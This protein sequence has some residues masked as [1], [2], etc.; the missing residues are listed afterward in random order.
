MIRGLLRQ[1]C[2]FFAL[3]AATYCSDPLAADSQSTLTTRGRI[4][5]LVVFAQFADEGSAQDVPPSFAGNLFDPNLPG[6]LTHFFD[7][8][9][10]GQFQLEGRVLPRW[11]RS[12]GPAAS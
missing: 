12:N 8:M 11:Y 2:G 5:A 10:H 7:E 4:F 3:L 1:G 6:S 9:S